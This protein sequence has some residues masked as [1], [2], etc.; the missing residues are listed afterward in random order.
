MALPRRS[1]LRGLGV[2]AVGGLGAHSV[3]GVDAGASPR[4]ARV[5][6]AGS[7]LQLAD[8]IP[9][10]SVEAHG[11]VA[12][13]RLLLQGLRDPDA[14]ALSDPRLF[15]GIADRATLFATNALVLAYD[16][17]SAFVEALE[18][19]WTNA[20]VDRGISLGRTDPEQ[21]PLG[22]RTVMALRLAERRDDLSAEAVLGQSSV[23]LE[24]D[25]LN[26]LEGGPLD[27]A[28]TYR[29]M[30]VQRDLPYVEL[31]DEIDFSNPAFA[32][33]YRTVS[34]DLGESTVRGSPIR[35]AATA[36]TESGVPW[37]A[38]LVT[39]E[40]QL[41][42]AGFVVPPDYPI[43]DERLSVTAWPAPVTA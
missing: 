36:L 27:A 6:V 19:D 28:F 40:R 8:Q 2:A 15:A 7:L 1:L 17:D 18:T 25:L 41:L 42:D 16:P 10:G 30:A 3:A 14:V 11:S 33:T 20:V 4:S 43:R 5:L 31:P 39:A 35:Y 32:A 22:Y 24:T 37:T 13:R 9:G 38:N 26:V 21:D 12:V 34:Y 23:F 29:N